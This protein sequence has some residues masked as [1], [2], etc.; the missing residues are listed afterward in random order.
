MHIPT[1]FRRVVDP[2]MKKITPPVPQ[3]LER[4]AAES[5]SLTVHPDGLLPWPETDLVDAFAKVPSNLLAGAALVVGH[6]GVWNMRPDEGADG[7]GRCAR[8][9]RYAEQTLRQRHGLPVAG[10]PYDEDFGLK[11]EVHA[12]LLR[13]HYDARQRWGGY[14]YLGL[15]TERNVAQVKATRWPRYPGRNDHPRDLEMWCRAVAGVAQ[16]LADQ[17]RIREGVLAPFFRLGVFHGHPKVEQDHD[18]PQAVIGQSAF[19]D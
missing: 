4:V 15:A 18:R 3:I 8:F 7:A 13:V 12:G 1:V 5:A 10:W 19:A 16:S 6:W 2:A 17:Q 14:T 9:T 11:L